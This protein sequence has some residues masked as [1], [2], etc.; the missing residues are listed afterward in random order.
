MSVTEMRGQ[1]DSNPYGPPIRA[2]LPSVTAEQPVSN[3]SGKDYFKRRSELLS[4]SMKTL[5]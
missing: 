1:H 4:Q 2:A 5:V 3:Y